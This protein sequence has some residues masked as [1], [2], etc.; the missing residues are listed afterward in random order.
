MYSLS[1]AD[2]N[3]RETE[4]FAVIDNDNDNR[5]G[6]GAVSQQ[7]CMEVAGHLDVPMTDDDTQFLTKLFTRDITLHLM[8]CWMFCNHMNET[9][10]INELHRIGVHDDICGRM[11]ARP[12]CQG[13]RRR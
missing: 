5:S 2:S 4:S 6:H 3:E 8:N 12:I 1:I 11:L 9:S 7:Q 10:R 13:Q